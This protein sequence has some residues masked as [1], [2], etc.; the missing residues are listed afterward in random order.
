MSYLSNS[1]YWMQRV[2]SGKVFLAF[3]LGTL[4]ALVSTPILLWLNSIQPEPYMD[5]IFHIPQAQNYC[6]YNFSHWDSKITTPPG[7]YISS[8]LLYSPASLFS[9]LLTLCTILNLRSTNILFSS[10]NTAMLFLILRSI[11]PTS[12][13]K[14]VSLYALTLSLFPPLYFFSFFYYTDQGSTF[15]VLTAMLAARNACHV[16]SALLLMISLFFRQTNVI[17]VVFTAVCTVLTLVEDKI[18]IKAR[19]L[20]RILKAC[21]Y[22][23]LQ[24]MP[25]FN[26]IFPYILVTVT[27]S[28]FVILNGG[29]VLGDK[30]QH[31]LTLHLSQVSYFVFFTGVFTWPHIITSLKRATH[32]IKPYYLIWLV[33][34]ICIFLLFARF[35][36][37][38]HPY[39]L[40]DNRHYTFYF[41]KKVVNFTDYSRYY[42]SLPYAISFVLMTSSL[43][44]GSELWALTY[45]T[46]VFLV[47]SLQPL[48][49]FRYFI[50]PFLLYRLHSPLPSLSAILLDLTTCIVI[51]TATLYLFAYKPFNWRSSYETQRF[52]W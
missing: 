3:T 10:L 47:L 19:F 49:E 15:F 11:R 30:S 14:L 42:L 50:L 35:S 7:L 28:L 36:T 17:W 12:D 52:I 21:L 37:V 6:G 33:V 4:S 29:I 23:L 2:F 1:T 9:S 45:W 25:S 31:V 41:W 27:F 8:L 22:L 5:E 39:L 44:I 34:L 38:V 26:T 48:L 18:R 24:L 40:A 51:N 13:V 46:S 43:L 32:Y 20:E 16:S